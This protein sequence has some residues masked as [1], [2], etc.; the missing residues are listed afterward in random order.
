MFVLTDPLSVTYDGVSK[1]LPRISAGRNGSIYRTADAEFEVSISNFKPPQYG[2]G[3]TR[4]YLARRLPDPTPSNVFDDY[5]FIY[6]TVGIT[7]GFDALTRAEASVDLPRLRT[8]LLALVDTT[9]Q[10]RLIA[11]EK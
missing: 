8:A 11:G 2:S 5:R 6:N 7:F 4:I 3:G 9:L 10:G 1:S